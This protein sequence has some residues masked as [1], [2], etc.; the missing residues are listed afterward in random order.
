MKG[1]IKFLLL[2]SFVNVYCQEEPNFSAVDSLYREDQFY[3]GITYNFLN[4]KP[5]GVSQNS[6][7][8]GLNLGFLRDFP[9][10]KSRT[11]AIAPGLGLSYNNYK[12]NLIV[13]ETNNLINYSTIAP[14][15]IY[16]KN[17]LALYF[18]DVPI[19]LRWRTSGYDS[20]IF[21]RIYAGF[22]FSYLLF[23]QS[24]YIDFDKNIKVVNNPNITKFQYGAYM[25]AGHNSWNF[26]AYYG[27][28]DIFKDSYLNDQSI[29]MNTFNIG[30]IFYI[31]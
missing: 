23:N 11:I 31:L 28:Q 9:I 6:F 13:G 27:L 26:Y 25:A 12:E 24:R 14:N 8:T 30:L 3:I 15:T 22:K 17:K 18:V 7:S 1:F 5:I 21:W 20:H 2:L 19:E 29:K 10:N 4:N 16:D